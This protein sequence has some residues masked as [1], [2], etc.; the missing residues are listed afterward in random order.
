[1]AE[2][3]RRW[4]RLGLPPGWNTDRQREQAHRM[5]Y[6]LAAYFADPD[7]PEKVDS[8]VPL[9][10]E[11]GRATISGRVDRLERAADGGLRVVD[12]KTG[13]SKPR[14]DDVP[15]HP[16]LGTYQ[17][18]VEHGAFGREGTT[19]AGAAL[20]HLGKAAG[21]SDKPVIQQQP[22]LETQDDPG[23]AAQLVAETAEGMGGHEFAATPGTWCTFCPVKTSCPAMPEGSTLR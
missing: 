4:G 17:L 7:R 1:V 3:E 12:Y 16:Q 20:L 22:P 23:W 11:V 13:S 18:A 10:V 9:R 8:E 15:T 5:A 2:V 21:A 14:A 19:S 6:R